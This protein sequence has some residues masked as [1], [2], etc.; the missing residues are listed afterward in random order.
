MTTYM[1]VDGQSNAITA[2]LSTHEVRE[3]AQ[4]IANERGAS[5][6]YGP[7]DD[8]EDTTE[9][10][11]VM[12]VG[13]QIRNQKTG[14]VTRIHRDVSHCHPGWVHEQC[15]TQSEA[16]LQGML[17]QVNYADYVEAGRQNEDDS[18][19]F[20]PVPAD[21]IAYKYADPAEDARWITDEA[22][23]AVIRGEDPSLVVMVP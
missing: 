17:D 16:E 4:R 9:V 21:A 2:G 23:L 1:I 7:E 12:K 10:K 13:L 19:I 15:G 22:D 5:V 3:V 6:Y 18:G 11:P 14:E 20:L 8:G